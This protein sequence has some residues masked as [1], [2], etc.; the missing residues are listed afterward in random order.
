MRRLL[1]AGLLLAA[2]CGHRTEP[3]AP[4]SVRRLLRAERYDAALAGAED[5]LRNARTGGNRALEW[6][7]RVLKAEILLARREVPQSVA[8]LGG[9]PP[10]GKPFA[11]ARARALLVRGQAAY[12]MSRYDEA[13]ELLSRATDAAREAGSPELA[14]EADLRRGSLLVRLSRFDEARAQFRRVIDGAPRLHAPYL[15]AS[16]MGNLGYSLLTASRY[17]EAIPW[18]ERARALFAAMGSSDSVARAAGNLGS[19][20][21]RLGDFD[22][23]R[24]LFQQAQ[25]EFAGSGNRFEQQIRIGAVGAVYAETGDYAAAAAE[26]RRALAIARALP[27][28]L[29]T[30]RWL[31][32][33]AQTS[34]ELGD[35]REAEKFNDEALALKRR[36]PGTR[37]EVYSLYNAARIAAARG[38]FSDAEVL[39]RKALGE[40]AEDPTVLLDSHAG[41]ADL[42]VRTA[43]PGRAEAQFRSA[44]RMIG[45]RSAHLLKDEYKFSYL[46]SLIRFYH[47]YV[48]FLVSIGQPVR[49]LE[50]AESSRSRVLAERSGRAETNGTQT[51]GDYR[52]LA[53]ATG[54]VLLEYWLGDARSYLWVVTRDGVRLRVL[55]PRAELRPLVERYRQA[56]MAPRDPLQAAADAGSRLYQAL[57]A[58]VAAE[59]GAARFIIVPDQELASLNLETLPAAAGAGTFWIEQATVALAPSLSYLAAHA[60]QGRPPEKPELLLIGDPTSSLAA[61]PKLAYAAREMDSIAAAMS[62]SPARV[63]KGN[64]ARPDAYAAAGPARFEFIHFA[65]HAA[66]NRESPLDSA[67]VLSGAPEKCKLFA[68]D[69]MGIPLDA[70]LVTISGCRSAGARTY[71]GEGLVGFAWAFLRAGARNVIAGLWDVDDRST[72]ELMTHLYAQLAK[73]VAP[74]DALRAAKLA[75]IRAGGAYRKPF[76]WAPFQLY[77]GAPAGGPPKPRS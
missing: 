15:E 63:L 24:R 38:Q 9:D 18:F 22:E 72:A 66:A 49:A 33:L 8:A 11:E 55:P 71:A 68:R 6:N 19:C 42:Y 54:A 14:L 23:A 62:G 32:N 58:P 59:R 28:D 31:S 60:A 3:A 57:L 7:F 61:Y 64:E 39:Y 30:A 41:L 51:A 40:P 20:Y 69:V 65:A 48:D 29:W 13:Q 35:W 47:G 50:V 5:G 53:R 75:L 21:L 46:A 26:Y 43:R 74:A 2:G 12:L 34:I 76:Y 27:N 1:V 70:E 67:V 16:A 77:M 17:D 45:E 56:I 52:K 73:G 44:L 4:E 25:A 10:A 36:L 37:S